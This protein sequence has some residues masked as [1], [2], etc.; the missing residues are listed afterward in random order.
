M[1][2]IIYGVGKYSESVYRCLRRF[3]QFNISFFV[4]RSVEKQGTHKFCGKD[5]YSPD[6]LLD[7]D[8]DVSIVISL[9]NEYAEVYEFLAGLGFINIMGLAGI[10]YDDTLERKM[11]YRNLGKNRCIDLKRLLRFESSNNELILDD[12]PFVGGGSGLLD[13][14]FLKKLAQLFKV[15]NYMEIG[16]YIG[17][18]IN[19]MSRVCEKCIGVTAPIGSEISM[20]QWCKQRDIPDYSSELVNVRNV[21]MHY[22]NSHEYDFSNIKDI[23]LFFIDGDHSYNGVCCDTAQIFKYRNKDSIV[24]WHDFKRL[25]GGDDV[26]MAVKDT[27]GSEFNNV[28][29]TD[30]NI[31]GIYIPI[32]YKDRIPLVEYCYDEHIKPQLATYDIKIIMN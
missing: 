23:D 11:L 1:E 12:I 15:K 10:N 26:I 3:P 17:T 5:V 31:C 21:F 24:V 22:G 13:Y 9:D 2:I 25:L 16:T 7:Y 19:I 8:K 6:I 14:A 28:Y 30:G 20:R 4:D 27:I 29:I 18:S 32:K